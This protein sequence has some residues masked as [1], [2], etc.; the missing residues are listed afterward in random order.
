M[1]NIQLACPNYKEL[2]KDRGRICEF[3]PWR[4]MEEIQANFLRNIL[5]TEA[6]SWFRIFCWRGDENMYPELH[7]IML[8]CLPV[9]LLY[10]QCEKPHHYR[11]IHPASTTLSEKLSVEGVNE[12]KRTQIERPFLKAALC[13][14][15]SLW[16]A[17]GQ[18]AH[19]L[20]GYGQ[21]SSAGFD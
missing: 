8:T 20:G 4:H 19:I 3:L 16:R 17:K 1:H 6:C 15:S 13:C 14:L 12:L 2:G 11:Q 7:D 21:Q 5:V 18:P 10:S 9:Q